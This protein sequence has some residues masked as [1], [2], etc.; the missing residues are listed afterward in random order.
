MWIDGGIKL[1]LLWNRNSSNFSCRDLA[2]AYTIT[3]DNKPDICGHSEILRKFGPK[4]KIAKFQKCLNLV[5]KM[6][7]DMNSPL[8][9]TVSPPM[10]PADEPSPNI[11]GSPRSITPPLVPLGQKRAPYIPERSSDQFHRM[12]FYGALE[13]VERQSP[14]QSHYQNHYS[15]QST[16]PGQRSPGSPGYGGSPSWTSSPRTFLPPANVVPSYL[17]M[18]G[19]NRHNSNARGRK[20]SVSGDG[21]EEQGRVVTAKCSNHERGEAETG[22]QVDARASL[23]QLLHQL[24]LTGTRGSVQ[25][26]ESRGPTV[27]TW[28]RAERVG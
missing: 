10:A 15:S 9:V 13:K 6:A 18:V 27:D 23:Q 11:T 28:S 16:E 26:G 22:W 8:L 25:Q 24:Q 12:K 7:D 2:D 3:P 21:E 14:A 19:T 20:P 17:Y 1:R 4:L 5:S